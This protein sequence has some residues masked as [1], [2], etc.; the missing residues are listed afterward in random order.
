VLVSFGQ[1]NAVI[2]AK[3]GIQGASLL[4]AQHRRKWIPAFAGMTASQE[5]FQAANDTNTRSE[6]SVASAKGG[7]SRPRPLS[8]VS[9][10]H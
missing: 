6:A 7:A 8:D 4:K 1:P 10:F 9:P 3:A 2:P 5:G